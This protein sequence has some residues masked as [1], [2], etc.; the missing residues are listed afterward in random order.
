MSKTNKEQ[1]NRQRKQLAEW[2]HEWEIALAL[3]EFG[4]DVATTTPSNDQPSAQ[5]GQYAYLKNP[6]RPGEVILLRPGT[7]VE[8]P[9]RYALVLADAEETRTGWCLPLSRFTVPA[10]PEEWLTG[11]R[12]PA[13][14][15]CCGWLRTRFPWDRFPPFWP[16]QQLSPAQHQRN[17]ALFHTMLNDAER[18]PEQQRR[19]GPPLHHPADPRHLYK[20]QERERMN[21]LLYPQQPDR[22][23]GESGPTL[24][25]S[26]PVRSS[27]IWDRMAAEQRE[28]YGMP[29]GLY[30]TADSS[31]VVATYA[32]GTSQ[33]RI[34]VLTAQ[35]RL[36][37]E[38]DGGWIET[39]RGD[40]SPR[41]IG[42]VTT[43]ARTDPVRLIKLVDGQGQ[44]HPLSPA[45]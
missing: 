15:V 11:L 16:V 36:C 20:E 32:L 9:P 5:R 8:Q 39:E 21:Q 44:V 10:F 6:P 34:R 30:T 29:G 43:I 14:R 25:L 45:D 38:L 40:R 41:L 7:P 17:E 12:A 4:A 19:V 13:L 26:E 37:T 35:G 33:L 23:V 42:G 2:L 1:I 3:Q 31:L 27:R 18:S 28:R 22:C 24:Y